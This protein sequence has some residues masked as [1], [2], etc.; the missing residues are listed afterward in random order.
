M[1][2]MNNEPEDDDSLDLTDPLAQDLIEITARIVARK[3]A[4]E[5]AERLANQEVVATERVEDPPTPHA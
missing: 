1:R 2:P 3:L 4:R 5:R